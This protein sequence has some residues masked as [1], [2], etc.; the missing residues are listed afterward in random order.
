MAFSV[1]IDGEVGTTGLQI[2]ARLADRDDVTLISLPESERKDLERRREILNSADIVI[3]CLP[4]D[5]SREAVGLIENP[6]VR[7][8]DASNAHR[9]AEGWVYGMPEYD[10]GQAA[11]IAAA[12]HVTNPGCYAITAVSMLHPL[13][14]AGV[15]PTDFPVTINA[16]SG[17]SG[18]GKKMIASFEDTASA[19]YT[20]APF[21]VYGLTLEHKHTEE[22]R[23]WSGLENC[24]LFVPSVGRFRQG[25]IVQVPLQLWAL[26]GSP[27]RKRVQATLADHYAGSRFVSIAGLEESSAMAGL[28]PEG[29]NGTNE[30]RLHVCGNEARGQAVI[31]GLIDNLGKGASGQAVQNMNLMLGLDETAGLQQPANPTY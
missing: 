25:M 29:L 10:A 4:D 24:P 11:K 12:K 27:S 16:I 30:L 9:V 2:R 14:A 26:P 22:I 6:A 20:E 3:L 13:V 15:L 19:G 8:I 7:V 18:G 31:M 28:E 23:K 1:F 21:R 17:Y 5:A